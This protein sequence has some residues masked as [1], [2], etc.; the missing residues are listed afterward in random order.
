[1]AQY[2]QITGFKH[3]T[4]KLRHSKWYT[5]NRVVWMKNVVKSIP[6]AA[7]LTS[8]EDIANISVWHYGQTEIKCRFCYMIVPKGHACNK[9]PPPRKCFACGE[10]GHT[11]VD[12]PKNSYGEEYPSLAATAVPEYHNRGKTPLK[13]IDPTKP[14]RRSPIGS[15]NEDN[16]AKRQRRGSSPSLSFYNNEQ[17]SHINNTA[18]EDISKKQTDS[19]NGNENTGSI[20]SPS[21]RSKVKGTCEVAFFYDNNC[22]EMELTGDDLLKLN[23]TMLSEEHGL[24]IQNAV[25]ILENMSPERKKDLNVAVLHVGTQNFP[26]KTDHEFFDMCRVF[27]AFVDEIIDECPQ[28]SIVISG[29]PPIAGDDDAKHATNKCIGKFNKHTSSISDRHDK[30]KSRLHYLD[31]DIHFKDENLKVIKS[32]Y[33]DPDGEGVQLNADGKE[34]LKSGIID[35]I[36]EVFYQDRLTEAQGFTMGDA[37]H[38]S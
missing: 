15:P 2:G 17:E 12:C 22:K 10:T 23:T 33:I 31:N 8:G 34:R 1:M 30:Y 37:D 29:V 7:K 20:E 36:K 5:G 25:D 27:D 9:A 11:K 28:T 16:L 24:S 3:E 14:L 18:S 32:L 6:P 4:H 13:I 19:R 38:Q 26:T 35:A 21:G